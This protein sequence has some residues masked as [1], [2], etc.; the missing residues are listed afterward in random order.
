M[1]LFGASGHARAIIDLL[2]P[3]V[4]ISGIFDDNPKIDKILG[5]PVMGPVPDDFEFDA[6]FFIAIGDNKL[7]KLL[8]EKFSSRAGLEPSSINQP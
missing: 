4:K 2:D 8:Q 1:Y 5:C 6:P 7:R 3:T